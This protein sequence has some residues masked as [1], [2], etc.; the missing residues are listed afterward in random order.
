MSIE[1][2]V[3]MASCPMSCVLGALTMLSTH[4]FTILDAIYHFMPDQKFVPFVVAGVGG[5]HFDPNSTG[6][7]DKLRADVC[8]GAKYLLT[9]ITAF[10]M[11]IRDLAY[12]GSLKQI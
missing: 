2:Y 3:T 12:F 8:V 7:K 6:D 4:F 11:D 10:R 9:D 5:A 1:E